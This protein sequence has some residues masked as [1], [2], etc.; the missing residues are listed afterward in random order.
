M[1]YKVLKVSFPSSDGEHTVYGDIYAPAEGESRGIVMLAHGMR[2]HV[3][4]YKELAQYLCERGFVFAGNEHLGH[5]RTAGCPEDLGYTGK[6]DGYLNMIEDLRKMNARVREEFP[7]LPVV[8]LG[9]SM[10]SFMARLY[11]ERYPETVDGLIIHGTGGRNP[12]LPFGKAIIG[13]IKLF[14]GARHRSKLVTGIAFG[15]YNDR[16]DSSE[17]EEAWL[18]RDPSMIADRPTDPYCAFTFTAA[19]YGDLFKMIGL[20]NSDKHFESYPKELPTLVISGE[21]DPVGDYGKGV[22]FVYDKLCGAGV[23]PLTLKLYEGARHELFNETNRY[24]VF[25]YLWGWLC[26]VTERR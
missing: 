18:T 17:G 2:D 1:S 19:G 7:G 23:K 11:A 16:F 10:G 6:K 24:E 25:E 5:G 15:S 22:K 12:L 14:F 3:S 9:H 20:S 4:R 21:E 13:L 26:E 8:L